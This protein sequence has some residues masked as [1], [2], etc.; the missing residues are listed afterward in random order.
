MDIRFLYWNI[1][2]NSNSFILKL[3]KIISN[4]DILLLVENNKISDSLIEDSLGMMKLDYKA[5]FVETQFTPKFYTKFKDNE[6]EY[7]GTSTSKRLIFTSLKFANTHEIL[8]GGIHFPSKLNYDGLSQLQIAMEYVREIESIET[9]KDNRNTIIFGDFN[10]N[11][12]DEGMIEPS[13][14]NAT[15]SEIEAKKISKEFHYKKY[16]YFYNPMWGFLG[17]RN[18]LSGIRKLPGSFYYKKAPYWNVYDKVIMRPQIIDI[19]DFS[20]LEI[21][22][23]L[24]DEKLVDTNFMI[25]NK[26]YSDHLPLSFK[27]KL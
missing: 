4:I 26:I 21:I 22:D 25:K 5:D 7:I 14:F 24:G 12:F 16:N 17:D 6:L 23:S 8:V 1:N 15:L 9:L 13:A 19:F 27:I 3:E 20:S 10:M 18:Y 2:N 11:P